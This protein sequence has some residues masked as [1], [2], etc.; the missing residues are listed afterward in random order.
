MKNHDRIF[1]F[2]R[3][4]L[5]Y[6]MNQNIGHILYL[7]AHYTPL[8]EETTAI[9][10]LSLLYS[11]SRI[12]NIMRAVLSIILPLYILLNYIGYINIIP[13]HEKIE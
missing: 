2:Y 12:R 10:M 7:P 3:S 8:L 4:A 6:L 11:R 13:K 5:L 9:L 1:D